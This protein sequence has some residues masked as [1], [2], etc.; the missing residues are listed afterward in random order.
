MVAKEVIKYPQMKITQDGI[1]FITKSGA[2]VINAEG[3]YKQA[4]DGKMTS[5]F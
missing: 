2:L 3:I 5:I 4:D 1:A